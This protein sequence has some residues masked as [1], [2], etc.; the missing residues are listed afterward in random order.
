[1]SIPR[2]AAIFGRKTSDLGRFQQPQEL[3]AEQKRG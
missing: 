3:I 2:L 1:M